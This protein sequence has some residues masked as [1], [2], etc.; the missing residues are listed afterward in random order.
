MARSIDNFATI[1][2]MANE[3]LFHVG[4]KALIT[5]KS[6]EVLVLEVNTERLVNDKTPHGDLPGG[7]ISNNETVEEALRREIQ[8]ETGI[9]ELTAVSFLTT[10][11]SPVEIPIS[12][13]Q[14]VGL[15]LMVYRVT[16]PD[17]CTVAI[18]TEHTG[19]AWLM[20]AEAKEQLAH[21]YTTAFTDLL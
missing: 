10:I 17:H 2:N 4:V 16:V 21:K 6:G 7:R 13:T 14:K 9:T 15:V 8:E 20:S 5:N 18:S 11:I 12:E 19:Y 3:K 1:A